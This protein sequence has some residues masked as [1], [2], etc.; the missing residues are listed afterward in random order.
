MTDPGGN[1]QATLR[2]YVSQLWKRKLVVLIVLIVAIG[3]TLAYCV[4]TKAKYTAT[5]TML[6][7]PTLSPTLLEANGGLTQ[8][9]VV[10]VPSDIQVVES[11]VVR[12]I[13]GRTVQDPDD[14]T[15]VEIAT[16]DAIEISATSSSAAT[17][18]QEA[19]L[20]AKAYISYEQAQTRALLSKGISLVT[21]HLKNVQLAVGT[22]QAKIAATTSAGAATGYESQLTILNEESATLQDQLANYQSFMASG[23]A[24]ESGQIISYAVVPTKP[25]SPKTVEWTV[26]AALIGL[27]LG[28]GA[29]M[30][31]ESLA[32]PTN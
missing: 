12:G 17:A 14:A 23:S 16:T 10:D 27:L 18:A 29:A 13:V 7:T 31:V 26:I 21:S 22:L 8:N 30:L 24:S 2:E 19:N 28:I 4:A 3:G 25:S 11:A 15:A 9:Q 6:L 1:D 32:E 20:Y 5:S